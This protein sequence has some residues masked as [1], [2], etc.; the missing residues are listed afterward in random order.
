M[1][2]N[3]RRLGRTRKVAMLV[4]DGVESAR[5]RSSSRLCRTRARSAS[6]RPHLGFVATSSGQQLAIDHTLENMPSVMFDAVL[7]P[8][9]AASAQALARN[10][11]AVH[12]VLEAYKHCKAICVIG[13]G[14]Q[15]LRTLGI[16]AGEGGPAVP[17]VVI[18]RTIRRRAPNWRRN[19]LPRWRV[20]ATGR[21]P[22]SKQSPPDPA[23][24]AML[25][26][27]IGVFLRV[28]DSLADFQGCAS[29]PKYTTR[30]RRGA[31]CEAA[32]HPGGHYGI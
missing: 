18:G 1:E 22:T 21:G 11:D 29:A 31:G 12:F 26:R 15:L 6:S 8:G 30:S 2:A 20:I 5:C 24:G 28:L 25:Q 14:V 32:H 17:G 27:G 13:E 9:G 7:I 16:G 3:R 4:A 23:P 19:S 10:G